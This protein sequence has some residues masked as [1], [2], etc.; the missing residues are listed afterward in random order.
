MKEMKTSVEIQDGSPPP[1]P[2]R[3][4][5]LTQPIRSSGGKNDD[6][7]RENQGAPSNRTGTPRLVPARH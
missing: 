3:G 7:D 2:V 6:A 1:G 5:L 4:G